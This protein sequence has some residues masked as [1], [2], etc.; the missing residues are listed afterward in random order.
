[1]EETQKIEISEV[2]LK[3]VETNSWDYNIRKAI[4]ELL[5]LAEVLMKKLNKKGGTKEPT[6]QEIIEEVG[7]V[8]IRGEILMLMF[9]EE[10]VINRV[11]EKLTKFQGYLN[12]GKYI[13]N[14]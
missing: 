2:T 8:L 12:E 14:I 9:G 13:G 7:D 1:M 10:P 3:L 4:E 6:D 5:E 11:V